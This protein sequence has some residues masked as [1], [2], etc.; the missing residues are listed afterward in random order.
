MNNDSQE[1][2]QSVWNQTI[3]VK[4]QWRIL[5][6]LWKFIWLFKAELLTALAGMI[7]VSAIN[8]MLPTWLQYYMDHYLKGDHVSFQIMVYVALIYALGILFKA[9]FQFTYEYLYALTG[10]KALEKSA[11]YFTIRS[12]PWGCGT[13]TKLQPVRF[14]LE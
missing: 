5:K 4:E 12:I 3:T 14:C 10:E 2:Y 6:R 11:G 9:V 1:E 13:L 8:M 7:I